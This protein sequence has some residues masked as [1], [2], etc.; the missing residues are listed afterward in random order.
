M[1][2]GAIA[3]LGRQPPSS[4]TN[5]LCTAAAPSTNRRRSAG[6]ETAATGLRG[7]RRVPGAFLTSYR[8]PGKA[9]ERTADKDFGTEKPA[10][11]GMTLPRRSLAAR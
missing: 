4:R 2:I 8:A 11:A 3:R 7:S 6:R 10:F 9:S 1:A 5:W